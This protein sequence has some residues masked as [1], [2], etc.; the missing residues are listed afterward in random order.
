MNIPKFKQLD[1]NTEKLIFKPWE[2]VD[3][4]TYTLK[5]FIVVIDKGEYDFDTHKQLYMVG[6]KAYDE[7][8]N[9][10]DII[11]RYLTMNEA[12]QYVEGLIEMEE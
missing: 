3:E 9:S 1:K 6:V 12:M 7:D 8:E 4:D 10:Y 2:K 11:K 5:D